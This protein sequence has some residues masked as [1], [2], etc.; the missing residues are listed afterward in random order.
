M[1]EKRLTAR[2]VY[3]FWPANADGDDI[4]VYKDDARRDGA[5][6]VPHAAAAGAD[7]GRPAEPIAR[8]LRRAA[9]RR[10]RPTTSARLRS[11]PASAPTTL[12]AEYEAQHDDYSAIIV[13]ALADRLA[14]AFAEYLHAQA[15]K[16]WGYGKDE[17]LSPTI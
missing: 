15:R 3:G 11:R 8:R 5:G 4:V 7:R 2:G 6:A 13:K 16:D 1:Q 9:R 12:V 14:E 10:W 17:S